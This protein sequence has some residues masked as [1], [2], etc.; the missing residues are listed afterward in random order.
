MNDAEKYNLDT[1]IGNTSILFLFASMYL[2]SKFVL[3]LGVKISPTDL[4]ILV[5]L[6]VMIF[7]TRFR[8]TLGKNTGVLILLIL[9]N[10]IIEFVS[11]IVVDGGDP[12]NITL[13]IAIIRNC[14]MVFVISQ[15]HFDQRATMKRIVL[16]GGFVSIISIFGYVKSLFSY[17]TIIANP[18]MWRPEIFYTL[19]MGGVM[20]LQGL[21]EDPNFFFIVNLIPLVFSLY[22]M[23]QK[24]NYSSI[25][26]FPVIFIASLL[27]F[28]RT[29]AILLVLVTLIIFFRWMSLRKIVISIIL[30]GSVMAASHYFVRV[31]ELP[32]L[33]DIFSTR[34]VSGIETGGSD[35]LLLWKTAWEGFQSSVVWGKGGRYVF[36]E[37][38]IY[39]HNDFLEMLSSHGIIGFIFMSIAYFYIVYFI[40]LK[41]K[42]CK[43]NHLFI[44]SSFLFALML[45]A[46]CFFTVYYNPFLWFPVAL[47]FSVGNDKWGKLQ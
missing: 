15:L 2:G 36:K 31:Y 41:Y 39:A 27:T 8:L 29:G 7:L 4:A 37:A 40:K 35:R 13:G 46:S 22:L 24:K 26:F 5:C 25:I 45:V 34:F 28:S 47:I 12:D 23:R 43:E 17:K 10:V 14:M 42:L 21:R 6:L 16:L 1:T 44:S 11:V 3:D 38:G 33:Y 20:R 18:D 9:S 19:G 30:V 32:T